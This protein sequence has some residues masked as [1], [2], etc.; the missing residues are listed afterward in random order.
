MHCFSKVCSFILVFP[1][2]KACIIL[3][4]LNSLSLNRKNRRKE[5]IKLHCPRYMPNQ[6]LLCFGTVNCMQ[7]LLLCEPNL[8]SVLAAAFFSE[9][10][11]LWFSPSSE[12]KSSLRDIIESIVPSRAYMTM[13]GD[14]FYEYQ[15]S[16]C[17]IARSEA[18]RFSASIVRTKGRRYV[19][20]MRELMKPS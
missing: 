1:L 19:P 16:L 3:S 2:M 6:N 14:A 7:F 10:N 11:S 5:L 20:V 17:H 4:F 13:K 12:M 9:P 8:I 18:S 15:S